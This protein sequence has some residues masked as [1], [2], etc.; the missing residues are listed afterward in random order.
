MAC[1]RQE[2]GHWNPKTMEEDL[3]AAA[4][5]DVDGERDFSIVPSALTK[6]LMDINKTGCVEKSW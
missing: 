6:T 1:F 4:A 2:E 5:V 3:R